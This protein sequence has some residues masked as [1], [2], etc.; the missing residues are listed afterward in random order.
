MKTSG[1]LVI[2]S[3]FLVFGLLFHGTAILADTNVSGTINSDTT[4]TIFESPY[5]VTG[6]VTVPS[7]VILRIEPGVKVK[8]DAGTGLTAQGILLVDGDNST[9]GTIVF[10]PSGENQ[11]NGIKLSSHDS[12]GSVI[13]YADISG[14]SNG[15]WLENSN[16]YVEHSWI[17]ENGTGIY[18]TGK[19]AA[20]IEDNWIGN[21]SGNG[22]KYD[23][24][25]NF[26]YSGEFT[27]RNNLIVANGH[28][29]I[30]IR[31][32]SNDFKRVIRFNT[33]AFNSASGIYNS[34]WYGGY[35][36]VT[37]ITGNI[38]VSNGSYGIGFEGYFT[39]SNSNIT[40]EYNDVWA[41]QSN[42]Y[43]WSPSGTNIVLDPLF[44]L[45]SPYDLSLNA[46][47]PCLSAGPSG[48]EVGAY[49]D[50]GS[51]VSYITEFVEH[52]TTSGSLSENEIWSGTVVLTD[53]VTVPNGKTLKIMPGAKIVVPDGKYLSVKGILIAEGTETNS[54]EFSGN[55]TNAW[56]GIKLSGRPTD[57]SHLSYLDIHGATYGIWLENS[58]AYVEHSWIHENGTGIYLTGKSAALI[59]DNWIGNNSGNGIKYDAPSN[60]SYSGE[61]TVRNNLIVANGHDGIYIRFSSNDFKRVIRFNTIAF[62]SASGIYNSKWYGGYKNVTDITGNIVVSNG[63]Y[64][65]GFEG[66]FTSSNSNITVEYND[67]WANSQN[68][69]NWT[70]STTNISE[71][72]FF[73]D[74]DNND[75]HL[76][77]DS[78]CIDAADPF[79]L[80][81]DGTRSDMGA[82]GGKGIRV[83]KDPTDTNPETPVNVSPVDNATD[84]LPSV[85]L[86]ASDFTDPDANDTHW[87][88][89]WQIRGEEGNY[90]EPVFDSGEDK[91]HLTSIT[92][93]WGVLEF[94][95]SYCWRVQYRDNRGGWS[96]MSEETC[97]TTMSDNSPPQ[98]NIIDGPS[99]G[100]ISKSPVKIGWNATDDV[101]YGITFSYK[102]DDGN[103]SAFT[104]ATQKLFYLSQGEHTVYVR[105]KD[106]AGNIDESPA[107]ITFNIDTE[108]P[109]VTSVT[110]SSVSSSGATICWQAGEPVI[111]K[112]EYGPASSSYGWSTDW[113]KV[114]ATNDCMDLTDLES[115]AT[116]HFR[117]VVKD[118][119]GYFGYSE[120]STFHTAVNTTGDS[121]APE[122]E[123]VLFDGNAVSDGLVIGS[124]G[125]F[126]VKAQDSSGVSRVEFYIDG[127]LA[128]TA[129]SGTSWFTWDLD[130]N[131]IPDGTHELRIKAFDTFNKERVSI[132]SINIQMS[133]PPAPHITAPVN[134]TT[135]NQDEIEVR[136][137][138]EK[139]TSV[140]LYVNGV[141]SGAPQTV[142]DYGHFKF[143]VELRGGQ[144][145]IYAVSE[146]RGGRSPESAHIFVTQDKSIP[147]APIG[148][149]AS[150]KA[151]GVV[152]LAWSIP[153][154]ESVKG[155]NIYRSTSPF[156]DTSSATRVNSSLIT[157]KSYND[158]PL[159]DGTYYYGVTGISLAGTEGVLS[160]VVRG[161][162]DRTPPTCQIT[163]SPKG[164]VDPHSGAI[165]QGE[166]DLVLRVS[167]PLEAIP[168]LTITPEGGIPIPVDLVETAPLTY[169]GSFTISE[170]TPS[171]TA[172][173]VF[174]A[175]DLAGNRG[176]TVTTG[177][178]ILLDTKGPDVVTLEVAPGSPIKNDQANPVEVHI[179]IGLDETVKEGT[180]PS[181]SYILSYSHPQDTPITLTLDSPRNGEAQ[182]WV[183]SLVL[184]S[185]AGLGQ[186]ET[187]TLLYHA[188][189]DLENNSTK[190][191]PSHKFQV[192]QGDLPPLPT[193]TG[194]TAKSLKGGYVEVA[195][196]EVE[197]SDGYEIYRRPY[198]ESEYTVVTR[199]SNS[200]FSDLPE[201]D[202]IYE[203]SV[204]S[205]RHAN[206]QEALSAKASPVR[207]VSDRT[208]P[209]TPHDLTLRLSGQGIVASW[210]ID[211]QEE[212]LTFKLYRSTDLIG[213]PA[214]ARLIAQKIQETTYIDSHP[215]TL[216][217]YYAVVAVDRYGNESLLSDSEYLNFELVPVRD[218]HVFLDEGHAPVIT[219][220]PGGE[221][222]SG[223][224]FFIGSDGIRVNVTKTGLLQTPS[225]EDTS[226]PGGT[227][228]YTIIQVDTSGQK[229]AGHFIELPDMDIALSHGALLR[230]NLMNQVNFIVSNN[231]KSAIKNATLKVTVRN[232]SHTSLP[233]SVNATDSKV[234]PVVI[235]GYSDLED[236]ETMSIEL[237]ITPQAGDEVRIRKSLEIE[238]I[239]GMPDLDLTLSD[240]VRG[241]TGKIRFRLENKGGGSIDVI[242]AVGNSPSPDVHFYLTDEDGDILSTATYTQRLGEGIRN[243]LN[244][245]TVIRLAPGE[246]FTSK[247]I[248][249]PVPESAPDTVYVKMVI[250]HIYHDLGGSD[251]VTMGGATIRRPASLAET[252]YYGEIT[253][254]TPQVSYGV[255][256]DSDGITI[257]GRAIERS[258]GAPLG[259]VPINLV[260][261][262]NGFEKSYSLYTGE[263]GSFT[264]VFYP[265]PG[266]SGN[267]TVS[268]LHPSILERPHQGWFVVHNLTIRPT[269]FKA[270]MPRNY[271]Q[272]IILHVST[273]PVTSVENLHL[274]FNAIDQPTGELPQGI[275]VNTS[276]SL[277]IPPRST[278]EFRFTIRGDSSA[279][280]DTRIVLKLVGTVSGSQHEFAKV[281]GDIHLSEATPVLS[282]SPSYLET[283]L[284]QGD[285]QVNSLKLKNNGMA[286]LEDVK[287]S[288][289]DQNG[290]TAPS[291]ISLASPSDIG[292]M[293]PGDER[294]VDINFAPPSNLPSGTYTYY[295]KVESKN[296]ETKTIGLYCYVTQS[297]QGNVFFK[298]EDIYSGTV[299]NATGEII[300]GVEGAKI[301]VQNED[302][303][304]ITQSGTTDHLGELAFNNLPAG[305]YKYRVT[306]PNHNEKTGSFW[307]K[308]GITT[309]QKVYLQYALISVEWEV[310]EK[311]I[312]DRYDITLHAT[313]ETN[314]PAAVVVLEPT[315]IKLPDMKAGDVFYGEF[316]LTNYGLVMAEDMAAYLPQDDENYHFE[317]LVDIPS[318]LGPHERLV[319][320]YKV[321]CIKTPGESGEMSGGA[322]GC[323]TKLVRVIY[324][325]KCINQHT[326][327]SWTENLT[328]YQLIVIGT[329]K[330][331]GSNNGGGG[332]GTGEPL[333]FGGYGPGGTGTLQGPSPSPQEV[334]GTKCWPVAKRVEDTHFLE[335]LNDI[336]TIVG[337]G[338][339]KIDRELVD[340]ATDLVVKVPG[341]KINI[342][343]S[344][345][346]GSWH[347]NDL[348]GTV[349]AGKVC[350]PTSYS[351]PLCIEYPKEIS[352]NG[353]NFSLINPPNE[354]SSQLHLVYTNGRNRILYDS[355]NMQK[356]ELI[357]PNGQWI[358][359]K[360]DAHWGN[361]STGAIYINKIGNENGEVATFIYNDQFPSK[362]DRVVNKNR[363][364]VLWFTYDSNGKITDMKDYKNREVKYTYNYSNLTL[365][366]V[367]DVLGQDTL[368][369]YTS[370]G[371]LR[372][373]KKTDPAGRETIVHYDNLG[374]VKSVVDRY[375]VGH[376]FTFDYDKDTEQYYAKVKTSSGRIEEYWFDRY[377]RL[378]RK[379]VNGK[380]IR[381]IVWTNKP[382]SGP[383]TAIITDE[384]GN[385]EEI[386]FDSLKNII[387]YKHKDGSEKI[388]SYLPNTSKPIKIINEAGLITTF[389]YDE[390]ERL[391]EKIEASGTD[392]E[393]HTL[394]SY[395]YEGELIDMTIHGKNPAEN[396]NFHFAYD[397]YGN[398]ASITYPDGS[399]EEFPEYDIMGNPT[400]FRDSMGNLW[401]YEYDAS[402]R[403]TKLIDPEGRAITY[404]YNG[405]NNLIGVTKPGVGTFGFEYDDHNRVIKEIDPLGA[406][407]EI[408]RDYDGNPV[409]EVDQE[410]HILTRRF[411]NRGRV[412]EVKDA[413]DD[414]VSLSYDE[415]LATPVPSTYP[416]K[417][418]TP[419][420]TVRL[421][422]NNMAQ[423]IRKTLMG[424]NATWSLNFRYDKLGHLT[425]II[426][427][428]GD[429][430]T[431][432]YDLLGRLTSI[433]FPEGGTI[434]HT[435]NYLDK[436]TSITD[437][438][439]RVTHLEYDNLGRLTAIEKATGERATYEYQGVRQPSRYTDFE[440]NVQEYTYDSEG[441]LV[442]VK[443]YSSNSTRL[444]KTVSYTY[445]SIGRI[446][447]WSDGTVSGNYT[448]DP[449]GR[450]LTETINY[451][452]FSRTAR[453]TYYKNGLRKTYTTPEGKT[454]TYY[455]DDANRLT[456]IDIPNL[457]M[458][459]WTGYSWKLPNGITFPGGIT[460]DF[461][462]NGLGL[463]KSIE[464]FDPND[465]LDWNFSF[466][467]D[468]VMDI[469]G[470]KIPAG[471]RTF[472]YDHQ[473]RLLA[474]DNPV[475][476]DEEYA[477][478][479]AG[480]RTNA[481]GFKGPWTYNENGELLTD[482]NSTYRYNA[483]GN[484][485]ELTRNGVKHYFVYD[486]SNR[487][488]RIEDS[489]HKSVAR[490]YYDPFGRRLWK[491]VSG[492]KTYF[493][494]T[495]EG[496]MAEYDGSGSL[497][498]S[499]LY[500]PSSPWS[501]KPLLI[502]VD[503]R[504][505]WYITDHLG[506]PWALMDINGNIVWRARYSAFGKAQVITEDIVSNL[507]FPGQYYDKESGLH[508]NYQRYYDPLI[509][510]YLQP[511]PIF[512]GW[513]KYA[514]AFNSPLSI[515]DPEG[516][517]VFEIVGSI[518]LA[519]ST[520]GIGAPVA[521][522]GVFH[523]FYGLTSTL[524]HMFLGVDTSG[525]PFIDMGELIGGRVG[526]KIGQVMEF[527]YNV[528]GIA[529]NWENSVKEGTV[530]LNKA[531]EYIPSTGREAI[532]AGINAYGVYSSGK[533][534]VTE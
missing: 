188:T 243:L 505:Y 25:S 36:N 119:V 92:I 421:Y 213:D 244:G 52:V 280:V 427:G 35:K 171:G 56:G 265:Q 371:P 341:G 71:D 406:V 526:K 379:D 353:I 306:A 513:G 43:N 238:C 190:I 456:G 134:G 434:K 82:Y 97:F 293:A 377:R 471:L 80:D 177:K 432:S 312:E 525:S 522:L 219:W 95:K 334:S 480:D 158:I 462:Y 38:V 174:S 232:R 420:N 113:T 294:S 315:T 132:Y 387:R 487:L 32:S 60:F 81:L 394:Y 41:N 305:I 140:I 508:Y 182:A 46:N 62:N 87:M 209:S 220:S 237:A 409:K 39:S 295:L 2:I 376:F 88:S 165:S 110:T 475:L 91:A 205:I 14:A 143:T 514:Y 256:Y 363:N 153:S 155:Y 453:F 349:K 218:V 386:E 503:S 61:F 428:Q 320:P 372:L 297:G 127:S 351:S 269:V 149:S 85:T 203:Y 410:G 335:K 251:Q 518:G 270:S 381:Q 58:N 108:A 187:L 225:Y 459:S 373:T 221:S 352:I 226:Y 454:Y 529:V 48:G 292:T 358:E 72:P 264:Y 361:W 152:H 415:T 176:T 309:T 282:W 404:S 412:L 399:V 1:R 12:D 44:K 10:E 348:K 96:E 501:T 102:V 516:K 521:A 125:R 233:F 103:W 523:G 254:I 431:Y 328:T 313:Y 157:Q 429:N 362:I 329:C 486:S 423:V 168:F 106:Y 517:C 288:L 28:D 496:L 261:S 519:L 172:Y 484:V 418:S 383:V 426:N 466:S 527:G 443:Y 510:R 327:E 215:S 397:D 499:Y 74:P 123:E 281:V 339:D 63:S 146:N 214:D 485:V 403:L 400:K 366:K 285:T 129:Y 248:D 322:S 210:Q 57:T 17:H 191:G 69:Y 497:L 230:R 528:L 389:K 250:D 66:Y 324:T 380:T 357:K 425:K 488:I 77:S 259:L 395:N 208:P 495:Q 283:G 115:N 144:N 24:P 159:S 340:E 287:I 79:Q 114:Y 49:G 116:Y 291:W 217:H 212:G 531:T 107:S 483:N 229:S 360:I 407:R 170:H 317:F 185:D 507:R 413:E 211:T 126:S 241:G 342:K 197:G 31:F 13:A 465:L 440:G 135:T 491:E 101:E 408:V 298:V 494:Y 533:A 439:G 307:I 506:T 40:V 441:H 321:T 296:Y 326:G 364:T 333:F 520:G 391:I 303:L 196:N 534:A 336:I 30:Y 378:L 350:D 111:G 224:E 530:I 142:D 467:I 34:K 228:E 481:S 204:S 255:T 181:L 393:R 94:G 7:G 490:Y 207:A 154:G 192:Y 422:Y 308:P 11:W 156:T 330:A 500:K 247:E 276:R 398:V 355:Q 479:K 67:V 304:S 468:Q 493:F 384:K 222:I 193:P 370:S 180:T 20:L 242:S 416:V 502:F 50:S 29:G 179:R 51:P 122:I 137:T 53:T 175:R 492:L 141:V 5:H 448:Y 234:V 337:C 392:L 343:R 93:P 311:T 472:S 75:F 346:D 161:V 98:T 3:I 316:S 252:P 318:T 240:F 464:Y 100:G 278:K 147:K 22:I 27:V 477:Y 199:T 73:V 460:G 274:E 99:P 368:Y 414:I 396:S 512:I 354:Y 15:I 200:T 138:A 83:E 223:Y 198:G 195:W 131:S 345:Y 374:F 268:A 109:Q 42:Y 277:D 449:N 405:A 167:E 239:D 201:E 476:P 139:G 272:E 473:H 151:G 68:Y 184:P 411:D 89:H 169:E 451:G 290:G 54:I 446:T 245:K 401:Q 64:G 279:D 65:I 128:H 37:D 33:I 263:D 515:Y 532:E 112:V 463:P 23:A 284:S 299:D 26:S 442:E 478:N 314:V 267:Y 375:G 90:T 509:G 260:L 246:A 16:A 385:K 402:G 271:D 300:Q 447:H 262:L 4:W 319:V 21:N 231:S 19:S 331:S 369:E 482:G 206:G 227:R 367:T 47:S 118:E 332:S 178:S 338:V 504:Y 249:I 474:A 452:T 133:P 236:Q 105:A 6:T 189:D 253:S 202:G 136:G 445:D 104:S 302:V 162:S 286:D 450:I 390:K 417:I 444:Q 419:I 289:V 86:E 8:F 470:M 457:G 160:E 84:V 461:T 433:K 173:A 424:D 365:I 9:N 257:K 347:F 430:V 301:T 437:Q 325:Y 310:N 124:S 194:L 359:Y 130:I 148:L 121:E 436:I 45:A 388:L 435:Y 183:G 266:E 76:S 117:V 78:P 150:S 258:T 356:L 216:E 455:Y 323:K 489:S 166:V 164:L 55:S 511:D 59:E 145:E 498:K 186:P 70:P 458:I 273:G 275:S 18:L 382:F 524:E 163:Y 120:D 344:Y 438:E 235:G 469:V